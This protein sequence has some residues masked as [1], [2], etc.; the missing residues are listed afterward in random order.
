[1][2]RTR[3]TFTTSIHAE[4]EWRALSPNAKLTYYTTVNQS[5]LNLAGVAE[6]SSGRLAACTGLPI[7]DQEA[8]LDELE[9]AR[10]IVRDQ[11]TYE[12][13]VRTFVRHDVGDEPNVNIVKG[14]WSAW[15][16]ILSPELRRIAVE[17]MPDSVFVHQKHAPPAAALAL[18][19]GRSAPPEAPDPTPDPTV[20]ATVDRTPE[21]TGDATTSSAS[22]SASASNTHVEPSTSL[23]LVADD[24][25]PRRAT[26]R[27]VETVFAAWITSTG[28]TGRTMLDPERRR[29]IV[30]A[31]KSYPLE[32]VVDA[33]DGWKH[34]AH[35]R[36]ENDRAMVYNEL[37]VLLKSGKRVEQ[38]RD[39]TRQARAGTLPQPRGK[40]GKVAANRARIEASVARM[41]ARQ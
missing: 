12:L 11:E 33:V 22:V 1:M 19:V 9:T 36:G 41:E 14:V 23:A 38:F 20:D 18:R 13:L 21:S 24:V 6:L 34:S 2:A 39:L 7:D 5:G 37:D 35:H 26:G 28:K 4:P 3:A 8:A 10:Y 29:L 16:T 27:D 32:D 15:S 31:L 25:S 40:P 17:N 30:G